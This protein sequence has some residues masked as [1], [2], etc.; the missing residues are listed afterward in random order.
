[1]GAA[2]GRGDGMD[3]IDDEPPDRREDPARRAGE[4]EVER[5]GG[6]DQDVWRMTLHRATHLGRRVASADRGSD[7]G[8]HRAGRL[9]LVANTHEWRAEVAV[10]VV[11]ERFQWR[12]I[13][14]ATPLRFG[15]RPLPR[16]AIDAP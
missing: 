3:L 5:L 16:Q 14:D 13:K 2:L 7:I 10:D 6:R 1:M 9:N 15:R 11:G 12:Y 8:R 4:D